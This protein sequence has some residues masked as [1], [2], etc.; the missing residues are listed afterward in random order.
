MYLYFLRTAFGLPFT[1]SVLIIAHQFFLLGVDR[2]HRRSS[3]LKRLCLLIDMLKLR[4]PIRMTGPLP[5]FP[6]RLQ[7]VALVLQNVRNR[8]GAD[9]VPLAATTLR[10][11]SPCSWTTSVT[12]TSDLPALPDRQ[13]VPILSP[14]RDLV[15]PSTFSRRRPFA[16]APAEAHCPPVPE[17]PCAVW[18]G[19]TQWP[20]PTLRFLH[21]PETAHPPLPPNAAA[22]HSDTDSEEHVLHPIRNRRPRRYHILFRSECPAYSCRV[23]N[24]DTAGQSPPPPT[25]HRELRSL[26]VWA[27]SR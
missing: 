21:D 18:F 27:K 1:A 25:I 8:T 11:A 3:L 10:P 5:R 22:V 4:I 15:P 6:I 19:S 16:R 23:T 17:R 13:A 7:A 9:R 14:A 2:N 20:A 26:D 12:A 24:P